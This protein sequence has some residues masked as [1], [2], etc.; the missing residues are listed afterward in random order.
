MEM[1]QEQIEKT[2]QELG[3]STQ[4]VI[5]TGRMKAVVNWVAGLKY[6]DYTCVMNLY[7]G[8]E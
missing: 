5:D 8:K 1:N 6:L 2:A 3:V 7:T 4:S